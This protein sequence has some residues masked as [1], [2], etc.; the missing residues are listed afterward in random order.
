VELLALWNAVAL[1]VTVKE[2]LEGLTSVSRFELPANV[3][4]EIREVCS[5]HGVCR[6]VDGRDPSSLWF[7]VSDDAFRTRLER[8]PEL[9]RNGDR[10][11]LAVI[12]R[13]PVERALLALGY[14]V[15]DVAGLVE[16]EPLAIGARREASTRY[17]YQ[18]AAAETFVRTGHGVV[19]LPCARP[20]SP[21][22]RRDR[23]VEPLWLNAQEPRT[24]RTAFAIVSW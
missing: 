23:Q 13:G 22:L 15:E 8:D 7:E 12:D 14:P 18:T 9:A 2:V 10:F 5:R 3:L 20:T 11:E 1:G 17:P 24:C 4:H 16:G 6:L 21:A 19:V